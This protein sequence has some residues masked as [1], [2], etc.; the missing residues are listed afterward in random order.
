MIADLD[1]QAPA[2]ITRRKPNLVLHC[3]AS[4]VELPE[5]RRIPTPDPTDTWCPI[6]HHQLIHTVDMAPV[7][8]S[9]NVGPLSFS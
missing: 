9:G 2:A 6:P 3:G 4:H 1:H 5:V 7:L 8:A